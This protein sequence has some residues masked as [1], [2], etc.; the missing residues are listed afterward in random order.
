MNTHKIPKGT[1]TRLIGFLGIDGLLGL[2]SLLG[3]LRLGARGLGHLGLRGGGKEGG[4]LAISSTWA[5]RSCARVWT[6]R[7]SWW[8]RR[9]S[10]RPS[11]A[12]PLPRR[13]CPSRR[14]PPLLLRPGWAGSR[15]GG[16]TRHIRSW[17]PCPPCGYPPHLS[18]GSSPVPSRSSHET[19]CCSSQ[20]ECSPCRCS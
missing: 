1:R 20:E 17:I 15:H 11:L 13:H 8:P 4:I 9:P 6:R 10:S 18:D 19:Q 2:D 16:T 12:S 14:L 7:P 5:S 3:L